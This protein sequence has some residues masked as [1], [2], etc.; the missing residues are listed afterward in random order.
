LVARIR[1]FFSRFLV[2]YEFFFNFFFKKKRKRKRKEEKRIKKKWLL[3]A[4]LDK[5]RL[6]PSYDL[7]QNLSSNQRNYNKEKYSAEH[8]NKK[9]LK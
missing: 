9:T 5:K 3:V 4:T 6:H 7:A 2:I 1:L 8:P